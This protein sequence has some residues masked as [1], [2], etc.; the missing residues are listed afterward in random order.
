MESIQFLVKHSGRWT[1]EKN[2]KEY[3]TDAILLST[4]ASFNELH[5]VLASHLNVDLTNKWRSF[6]SSSACVVERKDAVNNMQTVGQGKSI[7]RVERPVIVVDG[8]H[9]RGMYTETFVTAYTMDRAGHIFPLAYGVLDFEN[10]TSWTWF[11][12]NLKEAYGE[13]QNMCVVSDRNPS[14]LKDIGDVY[15]DVPD[16]A[17][18]WHLWG[19]MK[20]HYRKS[21]DALSEIF[22]TMA[23][24]YSKSEFHMLM[25]KVEAIDIRV[26]KYLKLAGYE[27]WVRSYATVHRGWAFTSNI[28]ESINRV[29]VSAGKLLIY[30]FLEEVRLLFAKWNCENRQEASYTFTTLIEKFNDIVKEKEALCTHMTVVPAIEY[31]YTVHDKQKN[32]ILCLKERMF[33]CNAFQINEISCAHACTVLDNM[34]FQKGPYCCDLY[35]SKTVLKTYDVPIYPL[36]HKDDWIIPFSILGEIVLASKFKWLPGRPAKKDRGKSD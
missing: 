25:E 12:E 13:R 16:Y 24:S 35:K 14:I 11:F 6:T 9:L 23:K 5:D 33:L 7:R 31:V 21:H 30:D 18:M 19:K 34:N 22:Y 4:T 17:C 29:L 20:K 3:I 26:K 28:V 36:L 27:K 2:Y 32:F 15:K 10:D 8:S 1:Y